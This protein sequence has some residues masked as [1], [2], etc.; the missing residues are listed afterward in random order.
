M[1]MHA[2][3]N[4]THSENV[5]HCVSALMDFYMVLGVAPFPT[6]VAKS[7]LN[8]LVSYVLEL[9]KEAEEDNVM[10]W[11]VKPKLHMILELTEQ[12]DELGDPMSFWT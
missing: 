12:I 7:E 2:Y 6:E 8:R 10:V 5:L 4:T 3:E 11:P 1:A 9:S